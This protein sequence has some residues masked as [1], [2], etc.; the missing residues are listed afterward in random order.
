MESKFHIHTLMQLKGDD[1][2]KKYR[3]ERDWKEEKS[4]GE[5][6]QYDI[7]KM[8]GEKCKHGYCT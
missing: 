4:D 6:D 8:D 2:N 7:K 1:K 3:R 5:S